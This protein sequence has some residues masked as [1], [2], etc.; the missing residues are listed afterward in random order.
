MIAMAIPMSSER[1]P[2][3]AAYALSKLNVCTCTIQLQFHAVDIDRD[4][5]IAIARVLA[6]AKF[7]G[8]LLSILKMHKFVRV[9]ACVKDKNKL[10]SNTYTQTYDACAF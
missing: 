1:V 4:V 9:Y 3:M 8:L 5:A 6:I 7:M 10:K 2:V